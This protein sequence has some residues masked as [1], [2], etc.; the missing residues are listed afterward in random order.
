MKKSIIVLLVVMVVIGVAAIGIAASKKGGHGGDGQGQDN[1]DQGCKPGCT[2]CCNDGNDCTADSCNRDGECVYQPTPEASCDGG[3]CDA[4]GNCVAPSC[5][6]N[7]ELCGSDR[8]GADCCEGF[9]C[10][11]CGYWHCVSDDLLDDGETCTDNDQCRGGMC[12]EGVC[13]CS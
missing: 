10:Y 11:Q 4:N 3:T 8:D 5:S 2:E 1:D 6:A 12:H 13:G 9:T 7:W